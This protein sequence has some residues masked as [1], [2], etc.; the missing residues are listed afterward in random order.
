MR[1]LHI[2][3]LFGYSRV[4]IFICSLARKRDL[5]AISLQRDVLNLLHLF[6][7]DLDL[8]PMKR[9]TILGKSTKDKAVKL[10]STHLQFFY[11]VLPKCLAHL[12]VEIGRVDR[13]LTIFVIQV[14]ELR[15]LQRRWV[16]NGSIPI[17]SQRP[18]YSAALVVVVIK[19]A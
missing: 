3:L 7:V 9:L 5:R 17:S 1:F 8:N 18:P 4:P 2:F 13:L 14:N 10:A 12:V 6:H 19:A 11:H 15:R 16:V